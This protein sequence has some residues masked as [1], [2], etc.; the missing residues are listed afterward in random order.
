[1]ASAPL[2]PTLGHMVTAARVRQ[3]TTTPTATALIAPSNQGRRNHLNLRKT[4]LDVVRW[5]LIWAFSALV[6][7]GGVR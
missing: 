7:L 2:A 3:I 1:M 5:M 6:N 4:R